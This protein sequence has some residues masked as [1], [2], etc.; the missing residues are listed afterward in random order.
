[1]LEKVSVIL[2]IIQIIL[3]VL[4]VYFG[5]LTDAISAIKEEYD[6]RKKKGV[7]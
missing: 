7:E 3:T 4:W 1:M 2:A 5:G 6:S